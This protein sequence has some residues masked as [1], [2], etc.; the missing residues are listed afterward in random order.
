MWVEY[1]TTYH[2]TKGGYET[3]TADEYQTD[4]GYKTDG[5]LSTVTSAAIHHSLLTTVY[6]NIYVLYVIYAL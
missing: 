5:K 3:T 2:P 4:G 6:Y 1:D